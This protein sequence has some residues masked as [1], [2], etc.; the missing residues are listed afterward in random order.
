MAAARSGAAGD[1]HSLHAY[2]LRPGQHG[3]PIRFVV[4]RIRDGKTFATRRV[5]A[6]QQGEAIFSLEASF[7]VAEEG[8]SHQDPMPN[9]PPPDDLPEW[10]LIRSDR[11][12][13]PDS[14]SRRAPIDIRACNPE[15]ARSREPQA[16]FRQV[17]IRARGEMPADP[18]M[19]AA[20]ITFASDRGMLSTVQRMHRVPWSRT[21]SAS[22]DHSIWFHRIPRFDSWLLYTTASH[23]SHAARALIYGTMYAQDGTLMASVAQEGLVR[24]PKSVKREE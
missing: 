24:V 16:P 7:A 8:I 19:H 18:L 13:D 11:K 12:V 23:A 20:V 10:D 15:S 4:D 5:A 6:H 14:W 3:T 21:A 2:F 22:L 1:V 17:W 9:V